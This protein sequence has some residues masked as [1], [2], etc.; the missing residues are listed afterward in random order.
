MQMMD[1]CWSGAK[2]SKMPMNNKS[3]SEW[4]LTLPSFIWLLIFF[5]VPTCIIYAY[6]LKPHTIYGSVGEG[7]SFDA[8]K[9]LMDPNYYILIGRT[10]FLGIATTLICLLL[11]LPVGYQ[12][13]LLSTKA[14]HLL[15][16]LLVLPFW[17]SFLIRIFAWKMLLHPEGYIKKILVFLHVVDSDTSLLYNLASV[18]LVMVYTYLPFAVFPIYAAAS[19]FNFQL[20]EAAMDLGATRSKAFFQVFIPGIGKGIMTATVMVFISAVGAYVIPDLV[21]G[22]SSE[23][24]GNKIAQRVFVD[25]N[26]PQASALSA[27]LSLVIFLPLLA[28]VFVSSRQKKIEAE[29]RNRE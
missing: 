28:I 11:A 25:R 20:L 9:D 6:A 21:G 8:I 12:M 2:S 22:F 4:F 3:R 26:L 7:F 5:L 29:V 27:L 14:R 24:I 10:L 19:K 23:M 16:L 18:V 17:S 13:T 1:L 15:M